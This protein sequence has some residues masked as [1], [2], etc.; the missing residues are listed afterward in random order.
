MGKIALEVT[1]TSRCSC[2]DREED[3]DWRGC[4]KPVTGEMW[5]KK[6]KTGETAKVLELQLW[7][8]QGMFGYNILRQVARPV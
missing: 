2:V 3:D 7:R 8:Q 5:L 6:N 4:Q 1:Q